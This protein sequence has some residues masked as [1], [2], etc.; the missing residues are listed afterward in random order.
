MNK[1]LIALITR[2]TDGRYSVNQDY[3]DSLI[4]AGS[5]VMM[6][7][8]QKK[9]DLLSILK[10]VDGIC[11][12]GGMDVDPVYYH[13]INQKSI[14][15][16]PEI[17]QL[18]LDIIA[19]A[20]EKN[21]PIFG[22]CRGLQILNVAMGGTLIQDV[23]PDKIDHTVSSK[24]KTK[25]LGHKVSLVRQSQLHSL[26]GDEIEVNSYHHQAIDRL[27][28]GL[29][30]SAISIDGII[31]AVEGRNILAVQW[32]PERMSDNSDEIFD[33]FLRLY[34]TNRKLPVK[35]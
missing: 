8:P 20:H 6:I 15:I 10:L 31:E 34:I 5:N 13:Q 21:I 1:P 14:P 27:A 4:K 9:E 11:L 3:V 32:H 19:I 23:S 12:P 2:I 29:T 7:L 35:E 30:V 18:D 22:I 26:F 24:N 25:N 16:E 17:D 33:L 28:D